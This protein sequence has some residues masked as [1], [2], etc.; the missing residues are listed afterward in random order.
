MTGHLHDGPPVVT[1]PSS[2]GAGV[3]VLVVIGGL[4][5]SGKTTLLRRLFAGD[6]AR[7]GAA[8][9]GLDSEDVTR[10]LRAAGVGIP[11]PLLRPAVHAGHRWRVL[12]AV[13][14]D[15]PVVLLSDPWTSAPWRHAV[16]CA[17]RR[18]GR[19]VRLV[20]LDVPAATALQG[21]RARGRAIPARRMRRHAARWA[22]ALA[23]RPA[24]Q[25]LVVD[26]AQADRLTLDTVL[27]Q[28]P[29]QAVAAPARC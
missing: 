24:G 6:G 14:G 16:L 10:Q 29:S 9:T 13:A 20:L 8:V 1:Q 7:T 2:S 25:A 18:A 28:A 3:P 4:P 12:R 17:A 11:Y 5:G 15:A 22:R 23:E 27:G 26:R 21:Q 19:S